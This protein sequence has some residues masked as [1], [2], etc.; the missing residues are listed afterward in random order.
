[1]FRNR[2]SGRRRGSCRPFCAPLTQYQKNVR[3]SVSNVPKI[4]PARLENFDT[5]EKCCKPMKRCFRIEYKSIYDQF[6][7]ICNQDFS[8][9]TLKPKET[10]S[11]QCKCELLG[12]MILVNNYHGFENPKI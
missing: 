6:Q 11:D 3:G 10:P 1:M 8:N 7:C 9:C 5:L 2:A 4:A 12:S